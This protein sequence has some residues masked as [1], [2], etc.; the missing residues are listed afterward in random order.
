[1]PEVL[2][3]CGAY[4]QQQQGQVHGIVDNHA[5]DTHKGRAINLYDEKKLT[6]SEKKHV[7]K[8]G[9]CN[10]SWHLR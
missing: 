1:L 4:R 3:E 6:E 10:P 7:G 2:H 8:L 5:Y 9:A